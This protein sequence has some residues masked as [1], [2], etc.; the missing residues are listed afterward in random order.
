M[1]PVG[2]HILLHFQLKVLFTETRKLLTCGRDMFAS[3]TYYARICKRTHTIKKR[4]DTHNSIYLR[5]IIYSRLRSF[6]IYTSRRES[7]SRLIKKNTMP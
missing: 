1:E 3:S 4:R 6:F 7:I 2:G 5:T